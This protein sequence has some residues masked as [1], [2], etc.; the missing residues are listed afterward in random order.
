[1]DHP[2][3]RKILVCNPLLKTGKSGVW[4]PVGQEIFSPP[5]PSK[6]PLM[7]TDPP[8]E[9]LRGLFPGAKRP[10]CGVDHP[11]LSR[12][13]EVTNEQRYS[14]TPLLCFLWHVME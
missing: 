13:A 3:I 6:L 10:E 5:Y 2:Y 4:T 7:P 14:A 9:W 8:L 1:M 12:P 11:P